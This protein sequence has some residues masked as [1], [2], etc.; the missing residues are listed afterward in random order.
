MIANMLDLRCDAADCAR[1][2]CTLRY[3]EI[4]NWIIDYLTNSGDVKST[5]VDIAVAKTRIS[6][7]C[8][9]GDGDKRCLAV[10]SLQQ[11]YCRKELSSAHRCTLR[12][13]LVTL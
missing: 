7:R 4:L 12:V 1:E 6:G 10:A 3:S 5:E 13:V 8:G 11:S 9:H 2:T